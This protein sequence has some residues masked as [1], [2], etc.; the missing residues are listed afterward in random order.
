VQQG[1][2]P[3]ESKVGGNLSG[4]QRLGIEFL[5]ATL[6]D[7]PTQPFD[8]NL[9][10]LVSEESTIGFD[11]FELADAPDQVQP[12]PNWVDE[13]GRSVGSGRVLACGSHYRFDVDRRGYHYNP[14]A[15]HISLATW[16]SGMSAL[17]DKEALNG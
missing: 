16:P 14:L 12:A 5:K 10:Y 13:L 17:C 15:R 2:G 9:D 3:D 4:Y 11:W 7:D 8:V 1:G 6:R